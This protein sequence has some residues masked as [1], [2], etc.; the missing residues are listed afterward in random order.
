[1]SL[2]A[3]DMLSSIG[4]DGEGEGEGNGG[5]G[6]SASAVDDSEVRALARRWCNRSPVFSEA[7]MVT[8]HARL[9]LFVPALALCMSSQNETLLI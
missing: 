7:E 3:K 4:D 5:A 8:F 1:M 2:R 9:L 6:A